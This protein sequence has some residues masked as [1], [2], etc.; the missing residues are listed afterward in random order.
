VEAYIVVSLPTLRPRKGRRSHTLRR[1]LLHLLGVATVRLPAELCLR[2]P[3]TR[4]ESTPPAPHRETKPSHDT[5][6]PMS[7]RWIRVYL[8]LVRPVDTELLYS[9]T[10][11]PRSQS[12]ER[13]E[14]C[15]VVP[16]QQVPNAGTM[17]A[18]RIPNFRLRIDDYSPN[19]RS[20]KKSLNDPPRSSAKIA[21]SPHSFRT[22]QRCR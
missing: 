6:L 8:H 20:L 10:C 11:S 18:R 14:L 12:W 1:T 17:E 13:G 3:T 16:R 5:F 15:V 22:H 19:G 4:W 9:A 21:G 2:R 7:R